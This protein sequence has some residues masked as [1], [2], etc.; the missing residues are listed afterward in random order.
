[1]TSRRLMLATSAAIFAF[2]LGGPATWAES[3]DQER[4]ELAKAME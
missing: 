3:S 2:A 1:M 4:A